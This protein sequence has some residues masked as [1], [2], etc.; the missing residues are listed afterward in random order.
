MARILLVEDNEMNRDMLQRRLA[1][2]GHEISVA[3]DGAESVEKAKAELPDLIL[4]DISLPVMDGY[5]ATRIL[6]ANSS[7]RGIPILGLSAHAMSGDAEK[8]LQAGCDD[9]DTKPVDLRRL[10]RKVED[11]LRRKAESAAGASSGASASPT[12]SASPAPARVPEVAAAPGAPSIQTSAQ[13]GGPT[14]AP[15]SGQTSGLEPG[16]H[17]DIAWVAVHDAELCAGIERQLGEI[18][19]AAHRAVDGNEI[20]AAVA[21]GDLHALLVDHRSPECE[22]ETLIRQ[23]RTLGD[24]QL[25]ILVVSTVDALQGAFRCLEAG[26][27]FFLPVPFTNHLLHTRLRGQRPEGS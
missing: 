17:R 1:R 18:G 4:M 10:L 26:A 25:R 9:Y 22:A 2:R 11:L 14:S 24:P 3:V 19:Y 20:L 23:A 5:E 7:T 16:M 12:A 15:T 6:K 27:D 21:R 8:A 13:T